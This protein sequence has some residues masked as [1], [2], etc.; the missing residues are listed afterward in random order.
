MLKGFLNIFKIEE[1]RKKIFVTLSLL[2]VY[3]AGCFIP[4]PGVDTYALS[5]F[6]DKLAK[7]QTDTLVG[8]MNLFTGGALTRL[9][10][11]ALGVM[12]YI[13]ASIIM[14]L[15]TAVVPALEKLAKELIT[16]TRCLMSEKDSHV[17]TMRHLQ[18]GLSQ[19]QL[20]TFLWP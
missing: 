19:Y 15:L 4:T 14:Q 16:S 17:K 5:Q 9:S 1:L 11:F 7:A 8:M 6:F 20:Q 3:R 12:P 18:Y 2:I 10:I 13:S